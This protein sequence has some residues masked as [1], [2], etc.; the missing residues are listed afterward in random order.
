VSAPCTREG[1]EVVKA[2]H[3][4]QQLVRHRRWSSMGL[5]VADCPLCNSTLARELPEPTPVAQ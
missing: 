4:S 2:T 1:H 5:E 3:W